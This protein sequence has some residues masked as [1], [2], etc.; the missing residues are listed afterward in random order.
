MQDKT[1]VQSADVAVAKHL[2][3]RIERMGQYELPGLK[4]WAQALGEFGGDLVMSAPRPSGGINI[5]LGDFIGRG[6]PAAVAALPVAEVFYGMTEKGFG[7]SDIIEEINKKLLFILPEGLFCAACLVELEQEGKMLAIWNGGLPDLLV[8]DQDSNLKHRIPS[9]HIPLGVNETEKADLD[10]AFVEVEAGDKVFCCTDG[11]INSLDQNSE[12]F[13]QQKIEQLLDKEAELSRLSGAVAKHIMNT[14]QVD[15]MTILELDIGAIQNYDAK[16]VD[17]R[18]QIG[19]PPA[20]WQVD[21]N[22]S[23]QVLRQLDLVPMVVNMLM[24]IQAPHEHKQRIYTVLAEMC[25]NALEHGVLEL[26]SSMKESANGFAEYYA[27]RAERLAELENAYINI[28]LKH[29][30]YEQGGK[31]IICVEDSG[32]GFDYQQHASH[33]TDNRE[34]LCGRGETLLRQLCSEYSFSGKGNISNA[35]YIWTS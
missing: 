2:F 26:E 16:L 29:E 12:A 13:G 19:F 9:A 11:I 15:D 1:I 31:L 4:T 32:E 5:F 3:E 21:F 7:L 33:L 20:N 28:S 35:V 23:A 24:Q 8:I 18:S 10:T 14:T 6:L 27:L 30:P 25:S 17:E 34:Q 22:F